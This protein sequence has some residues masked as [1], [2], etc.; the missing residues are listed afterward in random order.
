MVLVVPRHT[1]F[2]GA[3]VV[4]GLRALGGARDLVSGRARPA[5]YDAMEASGSRKRPR[6]SRLSRCS[7]L[8]AADEPRCAPTAARQR[9]AAFCRRL[10]PLVPR[11]HAAVSRAIRA[12]DR[13]EWVPSVFAQ[14]RRS[15][16]LDMNAPFSSRIAK[17]SHEMVAKLTVL[18][19]VSVRFRYNWEMAL[20]KV[21]SF[22]V[23]FAWCQQS[24]EASKTI[25]PILTVQQFHCVLTMITDYIEMVQV[26][27]HEARMWGKRYGLRTLGVGRATANQSVPA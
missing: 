18:P 6:R 22:F 19:D 16:F 15:V 1:H 21:G 20:L 9:L 17:I 13:R 11:L 7:A 25:L 4:S 14:H 3:Y 5:A 10:A 24:D 12:N 8:A 23:H 26:E 2:A 27:K